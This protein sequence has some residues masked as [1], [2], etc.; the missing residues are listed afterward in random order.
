MGDDEEVGY[1]DED[2][3]PP[4]T[5]QETTQSSDNAGTEC[6]G[7]T[8]DDDSEQGEDSDGP[9]DDD[10][11]IYQDNKSALLLFE[12]G[13]GSSMRWTKHLYVHYFSSQ[14]T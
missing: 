12:N 10:F 14:I 7:E 4:K 8:T 5:S 13:K 1:D 2:D 6:D 3:K 11:T 9:F